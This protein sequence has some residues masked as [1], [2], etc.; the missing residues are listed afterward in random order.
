MHV[1]NTAFREFFAKGGKAGLKEV[2]EEDRV[3][4][5]ARSKQP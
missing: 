2:S 4:K 1:M 3:G 5:Q